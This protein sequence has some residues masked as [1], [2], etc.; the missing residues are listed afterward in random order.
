M[1]SKLTLSPS[2]TSFGSVM[3]LTLC[4]VERTPARELIHHAPRIRL[5]TTYFQWFAPAAFRRG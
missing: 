1:L 2:G 4:G 5:S 3:D